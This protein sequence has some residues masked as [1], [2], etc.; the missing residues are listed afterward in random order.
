MGYY[1][2]RRPYYSKPSKFIIVQ[3]VNILSQNA[4]T[5]ITTFS[6]RL[7]ASII[8]IFTEHDRLYTIILLLLLYGYCSCSNLRDIK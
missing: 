8:F 6:T 3:Y 7:D 5:L 4:H 2:R 1:T